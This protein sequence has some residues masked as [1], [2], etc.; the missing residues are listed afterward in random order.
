MVSREGGLSSWI[1]LGG[2]KHVTVN[3]IICMNQKHVEYTKSIHSYQTLSL[4]LSQL[5]ANHTISNTRHCPITWREPQLVPSP[6][7]T[8][9]TTQATSTSPRYNR[10]QSLK[11]AREGEG[12]DTTRE[13]TTIK[14]NLIE[15]RTRSR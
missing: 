5:P 13:A 14:I 9:P 11:L 10:N 15:K 2:E 7:R 6:P 3:I 8:A 1:S 4:S 12:G